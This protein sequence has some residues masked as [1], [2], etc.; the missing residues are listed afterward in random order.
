ML[1]KKATEKSHSAIYAQ[2]RRDNT[3]AVM[4]HLEAT[5][6]EQYW[7][8]NISGGDYNVEGRVMMAAKAYI[9]ALQVSETEFFS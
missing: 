7:D 2:K 4:D 9:A 8:Q 6:P 3:R 5:I 1:P